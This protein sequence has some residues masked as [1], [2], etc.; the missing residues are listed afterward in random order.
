METAA[1]VLFLA[2]SCS[3]SAVTVWV[4]GES[5]VWAGVSL[6]AFTSASFQRSLC[7]H[8]SSPPGRRMHSG[9]QGMG[10]QTGSFSGKFLHSIHKVQWLM[11]TGYLSSGS[12]TRFPSSETKS[13][14][15]L[16]SGNTLIQVHDADSLFLALTLPDSHHIFLLAVTI[17][18]SSVDYILQR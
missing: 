12:Y 17:F 7:C 10:R 5:R 3:I 16:A 2:A 1:L 14:R 4:E 6:H 15:Q 18:F 9:D 8:S 11:S 13:S